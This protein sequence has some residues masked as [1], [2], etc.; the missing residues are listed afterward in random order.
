[1]FGTESVLIFELFDDH[2]QFFNLCLVVAHKFNVP[3]YLS[4]ERSH[5]VLAV[6]GGQEIFEMNQGRFVKVTSVFVQASDAFNVVNNQ[7]FGSKINAMLFDVSFQLLQ[8][9]SQPT[10]FFL[11]TINCSLKRILF[12]FKLLPQL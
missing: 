12:F 3:V 5:V 8:L 6:A 7:L 10:Q 11:L 9:S 1:M 4:A 2:E